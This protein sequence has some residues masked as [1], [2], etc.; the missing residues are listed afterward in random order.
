[1]GAVTTQQR[2]HMHARRSR[3]WPMEWGRRLSV[4][5][6]SQSVGRGQ[7]SYLW[8]PHLVYASPGLVVPQVASSP[9]TQKID[10]HEF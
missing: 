5:S 2:E 1:M 7:Y 6:A 3:V 8:A 4:Q 10:M 9:P